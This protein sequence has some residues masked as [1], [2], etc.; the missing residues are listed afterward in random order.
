ME[1]GRFVPCEELCEKLGVDYVPLDAAFDAGATVIFGSN[2]GGKTVVLKTLAFLQL[3]AQT[4]LFVPARRFETRVFRAFHYIGEGAAA[5]RPKGSRASASRSAS[6]RRPGP[7][8]NGARSCSSTSSP[9]HQL[10]G[11]GGLISAILERLVA[12][13]GG[14]GLLLHHFRGVRP[15]SPA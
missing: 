13:E 15:A 4:G 11:G 9:H 1:G 7:I 12:A 14:I 8:W 10:P 3:C 6:S 5:R 2:M